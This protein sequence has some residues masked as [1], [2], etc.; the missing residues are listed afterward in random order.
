[1]GCLKFQFENGVKALEVREDICRDYNVSIDARSREC[2]W[3]TEHVDSWYKN[4]EGRVS[5]NW[6][7]THWEW[8]QQTRTPDPKDFHIV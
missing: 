4:S 1:M 7:G 2:A 5:Q 6:P 3:G 8:W